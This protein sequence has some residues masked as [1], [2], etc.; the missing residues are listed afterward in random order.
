MAT[1]DV[2]PTYLTVSVT[3]SLSSFGSEK[4]F[5]SS[6]TISDLKV[7]LHYLKRLYYS[8]ESTPYL[9]PPVQLRSMICY[10]VV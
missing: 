9:I 4:R 7:S 2:A 5:P 8:N 1:V 3:S 10:A 6:V